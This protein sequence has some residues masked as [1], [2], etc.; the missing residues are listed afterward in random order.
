M[1]LY[2]RCR[3]TGKGKHMCKYMEKAGSL[4]MSCIV[5]LVCSVSSSHWVMCSDQDGSVTIQYS[6]DGS[7]C[8]H[9]MS[10]A[11]PPRENDIGN[12][13]SR[14]NSR[15]CQCKDISFSVY[16][17]ITSSDFTIPALRYLTT[18][19]LPY[20]MDKYH[21]RTDARSAVTDRQD[22][23]LCGILSR[24]TTNLRI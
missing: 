3:V 10:K 17:N 19:S 9:S 18:V 21:T 2:P 20:N 22:V 13:H 24:R 23:C 4:V 12:D 1:L 5:L 7:H 14:L 11:A 8:A 15:M 6:I 16:R